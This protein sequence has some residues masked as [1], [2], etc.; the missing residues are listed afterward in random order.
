MFGPFTGREISDHG[1]KFTCE[2][3][4]K[5]VHNCSFG[6]F[7]IRRILELSIKIFTLFNRDL[8]N[9]HDIVE[10]SKYPCKGGGY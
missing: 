9:P 5:N 1:P 4:P 10:K 6:T 7:S 2:R 8:V 3:V